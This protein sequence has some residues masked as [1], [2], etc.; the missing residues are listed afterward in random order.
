[1]DTS[2][3][4]ITYLFPKIIICIVP[5]QA[6]LSNDQISYDCVVIDLPYKLI[7]ISKF[8]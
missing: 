8:F 5:Y 1:M 7:K 2:G 6:T 4:L 3:A